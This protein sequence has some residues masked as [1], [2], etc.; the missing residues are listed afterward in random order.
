[1]VPRPTQP[2]IPP[3]S[4]NELRL[5]RQRQVWF[6]SLVDKRVVVQ[7]KLCDPLTTGAMP[8]RFCD[9]VASLKVL[10]LYRVLSTF[11]F[12]FTVCI[13]YSCCRCRYRFHGA[14]SMTSADG[15][16]RDAINSIRFYYAHVFNGVRRR[17]S[18]I[19]TKII[20]KYITAGP[21][22]LSLPRRP[23]QTH[24]RTFRSTDQSL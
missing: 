22:C 8:E 2:F 7:V 15:K 4:V 24:G 23:S 16:H 20:R 14:S 18:I 3:G 11:A 21:L 10:G 9:E 12:A 6:I 13:V 19:Y 5:V 1:V 17:F